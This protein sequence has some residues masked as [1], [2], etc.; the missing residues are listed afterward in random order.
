METNIIQKT[1]YKELLS[2]L[3][4]I[5]INGN[6]GLDLEIFGFQNL[7]R[8]LQI[9]INGNENRNGFI[10]IVSYFPDYFKSELLETKR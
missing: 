7:S 9:G 5:G 3:L 1:F 10:I 2:R 6:D 8:L 4:Q